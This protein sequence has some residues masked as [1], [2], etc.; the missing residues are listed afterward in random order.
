MFMNKLFLS[1]G[2]D[3]EEFEFHKKFFDLLPN[4]KFIYIPVAME[5]SKKYPYPKCYEWIMGTFSEVAGSSK[6]EIKMVTD[7]GRVDIEYLRSYSGIYIGGGNTYKLLRNIKNM[8][9]DVILKEFLQNYG[10]IYGG[11]ARAII[12]GKNIETSGD[13]NN[14]NYKET[15]GLNMLRD[16]SVVC[17]YEGTDKEKTKIIEFFRKHKSGVIA[18]PKGTGLVVS[19]KKVEVIGKESATAFL[20]T[21]FPFEISKGKINFENHFK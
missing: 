9:F 1:G 11:S 5:G 17:H 21:G 3:N 15:D 13:E 10:P 20:L 19:D 7:L 16:L 2:G 12:F 4:K 14:I 8:G 6:F 18:L